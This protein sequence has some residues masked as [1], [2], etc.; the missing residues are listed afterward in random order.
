MEKAQTPEL[1]SEA[2]KFIWSFIRIII[3]YICANPR[4]LVNW[5]SFINI[6]IFK[7]YGKCNSWCLSHIISSFI[8]DSSS[9]VN[10]HEHSP[11]CSIGLMFGNLLSPVLF[12]QEH[13]GIF[14]IGKWLLDVSQVKIRSIISKKG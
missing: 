2:E 8:I 7:K 3:Y 6:D 11:Q 5:T 13:E 10:R 1:P 14:S 9:D 12:D 4:I